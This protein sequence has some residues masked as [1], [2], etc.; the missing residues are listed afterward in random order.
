MNIL[1]HR[2][3]RI[4]LLAAFPVI[5]GIAVLSMAAKPSP[6]VKQTRSEGSVKAVLSYE[7][8]NSAPRFRNVRL[9]IF[10]NGR[11]VFNEA[12]A[13]DQVDDQV[14]AERSATAFQVRDLDQD[15]QPE[16]IVDMFTG[17]THCC[18]YSQIYRFDAEVNTY[19]P[20]QHKWGNSFYQLT[21]LNK[22]GL[23]E[24][25]S[26]DDRFTGQ[27]TSYAASANPLQIWRYEQGQLVDRT[28]EYTAALESSAQQHLIAMQR[29][30]TKPR[31]AKGVIAAYLADRYSLGQGADSWK[32]IEQLYQGN[33][34]EEFFTAMEKFLHKTG[35]IG[36]PD[37]PKTMAT[38]GRGTNTSA[39]TNI[40]D[41]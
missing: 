22:D 25:Q 36:T 26:R 12:V 5:W 21:D 11:R 14:L 31:D 37:K 9:K 24:F 13:R 27:F 3:T 18:T 10:Q 4:S 41:N 30:A 8:S 32:L 40:A 19:S 38:T 29:V 39:N 23:L 16:I 6:W 17:G 7:R 15:G 1:K 35:Y 2:L 34:R 20:I 28:A 33:D